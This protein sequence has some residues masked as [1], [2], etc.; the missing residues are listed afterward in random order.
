MPN[1][2]EA[3]FEP[4]G[5]DCES[6]RITV[7]RVASRKAVSDLRRVL[8]S[9]LVVAAMCGTSLGAQ[10]STGPA[11]GTLIVDGGGATAPVVRQFVA[12]AGGQRS[13]IVVI[14]TGASAI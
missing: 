13:E 5:I 10:R 6:G 14:P 12:L 3:P 7:P 9:S 11:A 1:D 2:S 4:L 8:G